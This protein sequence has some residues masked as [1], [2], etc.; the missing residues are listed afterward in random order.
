MALATI[1]AL[2]GCDP[3][4]KFDTNYEPELVVEGSITT[5]GF[6]RVYLSESKSLNHTLDSLTLSELPVVSAKV[7]VS[8]GS[9]TEILVGRIDRNRMPYFA[10]TG[11]EIRGVPGRTYTLTITYHDRVMTAQTTIP[12]VVP[13]DSLRLR[14]S[15]ESDTLYQATG[16]FRDPEGETNYYKIFTQ[17]EE[18]DKDLFNAFMG[19][20]SD[21]ILSHPEA[22]AEIYRAF[23]H[24]TVKGDKYT[25]FFKPGEVVRFCFAQV[26]LAGFR[27]WSLYENE[28]MNNSNPI[29]PSTT[30]LPGNVDGALGLWM[31]YGAS[32]YRVE[33]KDTCYSFLPDTNN[34]SSIFTTSSFIK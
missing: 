20:F 19:S 22:E 24:T 30:N 33:V 14:P 21:E 26:P 15:A 9:R 13:L 4:W 27:F 31:G 25:P 18:K 5:N 11:S 32:Y 29:I 8:D 2:Q 10:Y 6:S 16:Y 34:P 3:D 1:V 12:K 17:V 28:V 23:R 7:T